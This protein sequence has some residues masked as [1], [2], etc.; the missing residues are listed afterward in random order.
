MIRH[1]IFLG[2]GLSLCGCS[3]FLP[4]TPKSNVSISRSEVNAL[5]KIEPSDVIE[6][7]EQWA[8]GTV[9]L[10]VREY[11]Q[12]SQEAEEVLLSRELV[13]FRSSDPTVAATLAASQSKDA[14]EVSS[15]GL[16]AF[17]AIL[18]PGY[19]LGLLGGQSETR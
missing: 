19:I 4:P 3:L 15:L 10:S 9:Y 6:L 1:C 18:D 16:S 7:P 17:L 5:G 8:Q 2:F 13:V 11:Y 12:P 14:K